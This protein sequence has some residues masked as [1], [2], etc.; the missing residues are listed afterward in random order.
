MG[1]RHLIAVKK[2][3]EFKVAQYGQ[4]DGYPGGVGTDVFNFV[5]NKE[6]LNTLKEKLCK[7]RFL[8][9]EKDKDFINEFDENSKKKELTIK[10]EDWYNKYISRD[11][12]AK[13]LYNIAN[14]EEESIVLKNNISFVADS[15]FCEWA[16]VIDFDRN[17]LI[18]F[19]G[20][21]QIPLTEENYFY[22]LDKEH[23]EYYAVIEVKIFDLDNLP[24]VNELLNIDTPQEEDE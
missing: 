1:T 9:H 17:E 2:D 5:K 6:L 19:K 18:V 21:N 13:V 11:L 22:S 12:S 14:S 15:L 16:Y 24:D 20:F 3:S 23:H 10:Q 4:W 8:D 7:I